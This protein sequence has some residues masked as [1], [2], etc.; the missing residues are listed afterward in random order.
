MGRELNESSPICNDISA[1]FENMNHLITCKNL[2]RFKSESVPKEPIFSENTKCLVQL[3]Q[4]V[5]PICF[6][7]RII[8]YKNANGDWSN[9]NPTEQ[10]NKFTDDL[11]L[12]QKKSFIPIKNIPEKKKQ[13]LF[14]LRKGDQF[15]R[16]TI[17]DNKY[18]IGWFRWLL[19][20]DNISNYY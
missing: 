17:L 14:V 7:M 2:H 20:S 9:W 15:S 6:E 4:A 11:N 18:V 5:S 13:S 1:Y 10:F 19:R 3:L 8:K 16:C 12:F